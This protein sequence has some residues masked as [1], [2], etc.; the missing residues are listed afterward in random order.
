MQAQAVQ[1]TS[2]T[3]AADAHP[4]VSGSLTS[5]T[6]SISTPSAAAIPIASTEV[7]TD[8][9]RTRERYSEASQLLQDAVK[10]HQ[11]WGVF[12]F[13]E[14]TGEPEGFNDSW[15]KDKINEVLKSRKEAMQKLSGWGKYEHLIQ[16]AFTAFSPFAKNFLT[17]AK[18]A[19]QVSP[20]FK[21]VLTCKI[22][23]LNPYGLLCGGLLLL[24][25][26]CAFE[27]KSNMRVD[28]G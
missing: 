8:R 7:Y 24:I 5:P 9:E 4:P 10:G 20:F 19:Q 23:L 3:P 22:A 26:V 21:R 27:W 11:K 16:C 25:T 6:H 28:C 15:F 18:E 1:T 13:P 14:I 17:I 2:S 12:E